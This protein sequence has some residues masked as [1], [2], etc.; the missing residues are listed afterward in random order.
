MIRSPARAPQCLLALRACAALLAFA[1]PP[2][3]PAPFTPASQASA[4][5]V[6]AGNLAVSVPPDVTTLVPIPV[7]ELAGT[8]VFFTSAR[9]QFLNSDRIT[10]TAPTDLDLSVAPFYEYTNGIHVLL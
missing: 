8:D 9:V 5:R 7:R 6:Q 1:A 10:N 2:F 3:P 4:E